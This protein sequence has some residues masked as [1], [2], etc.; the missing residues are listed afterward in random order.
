MLEFCTLVS[1]FWISTVTSSHNT[2]IVVA[3][4]PF[5][6]QVKSYCRLEIRENRMIFN[7][8]HPTKNP[9]RTCTS[10]I[11]KTLEATCRFYQPFWEGFSCFKWQRKKIPAKLSYWISLYEILRSIVYL[12]LHMPSVSSVLGWTIVSFRTALPTILCLPH[13]W[14]DSALPQ[15]TNPEQENAGHLQHYF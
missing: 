10:E 12:R 11:T 7:L 9:R 5:C 2:S 15:H 3:H 8:G 1:T 6:P 4:Q 13:C 14:H